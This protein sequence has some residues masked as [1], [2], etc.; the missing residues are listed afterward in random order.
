[1]WRSLPVASSSMPNADQQGARDP[2]SVEELLRA[3][4]WWRR[5]E[6]DAGDALLVGTGESASAAAAIRREL[7]ARGVRY[8]WDEAERRYERAPAADRGARP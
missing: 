3:L 4:T 7:D 1:M 6:G 2:R 8:R 5:S